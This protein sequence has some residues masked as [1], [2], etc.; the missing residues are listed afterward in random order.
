MISKYF[1]ANQSTHQ[2]RQTLNVDE[3]NPN[4]YNILEVTN[5]TLRSQ[6]PIIIYMFDA[7]FS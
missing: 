4:I 2:N 6:E 3:Y 5:S 1:D 7:S